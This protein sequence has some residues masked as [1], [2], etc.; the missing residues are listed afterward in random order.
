VTSSSTVMTVGAVGIVAGVGTA[1]VRGGLVA[2][3]SST[4]ITLGVGVAVASGET[5]GNDCGVVVAWTALCAVPVVTPRELTATVVT[6]AMN[7]TLDTTMA[8]VDLRHEAS[9]ASSRRPVRCDR[10]GA[11]RITASPIAA[12]RQ[13]FMHVATA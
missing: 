13:F 4:T 12:S 10:L 1:V 2:V 5:V 7:A 3:G 9:A 11:R 8:E 6:I